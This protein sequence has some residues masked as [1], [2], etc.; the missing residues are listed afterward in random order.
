MFSKRGQMTVFIGIAIIL[1]ILVAMGIYFGSDIG[2]AVGIGSTLSYPS[3]VSEVVD[4]IQEC[5]DD[6][7]YNVV[8]T[9][10][11]TGGY[12]DLPEKSFLSVEYTIA[13]PYYYYD[14]E[15]LTITI[16]DMQTEMEKFSDALMTNCVD[17]DQF[18]GLGVTGEEL[19]TTFT[20]TEGKVLLEV[21][22]PFEV[23]A[24]VST[25]S[26]DEEYD[27]TIYANL[28]WLNTVAANI[29][30]ND[31]AN[32]EEVD[33]EYMLSQGVYDITYYV[34]D[35]DTY[36]YKME[37]TTSFDEGESLIYMFSGYFPLS[38]EYEGLSEQ[39]YWELLI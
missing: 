12:Y 23:A 13:S 32:P 26:V 8:S 11:Y 35:N 38:E 24:G 4:H 5:V 20:I 33:L 16:E 10:G 25:Y 14:G 15:D 1:V 7:A 19:D 22:Y 9:I 17:F 6:T 37:D 18:S 31:I 21:N 36:V 39:E 3:E 27:K 34:F 2:S 28:E 29:V 30:A